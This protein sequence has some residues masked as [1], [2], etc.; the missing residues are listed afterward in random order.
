MTDSDFSVTT[1]WLPSAGDEL[2]RAHGSKDPERTGRVYRLACTPLLVLTIMNC[3][4]LDVTYVVEVQRWGLLRQ[5]L[6]Q[7]DDLAAIGLSHDPQSI[8]ARVNWPGVLAMLFSL[9]YVGVARST[10]RWAPTVTWSVTGMGCIAVFTATI[11]GVI[12]DLPGHATGVLL[13]VAISAAWLVSCAKLNNVDNI[14]I[15]VCHHHPGAWLLVYNLTLITPLAIGRWLFGHGVERTLP[16]DDPARTLLNNQTLLYLVCGISFGVGLWCLERLLP[17]WHER[18]LT[19]IVIVLIVALGPGLS[20]GGKY[21]YDSFSPIA[22]AA[23]QITPTHPTAPTLQPTT[24]VAP[25]LA[26]SLILSRS[27]LSNRAGINASRFA[28]TANPPLD[29]V[30]DKEFRPEVCL[31]FYHG[32]ISAVVESARSSFKIVANGPGKNRVDT[33]QQFVWIA[34][35][36]VL[37]RKQFARLEALVASCR[38]SSDRGARPWSTER[39]LILV[40]SATKLSHFSVLETTTKEQHKTFVVRTFWL[41]NEAVI[42]LEMATS[43]AA[44]AP[45]ST[46]LAVINAAEEQVMAVH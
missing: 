22:V 33:V 46:D 26:S 36:P 6:K 24:P 38:S 11:P 19:V 45:A 20:V 13:A 9:I 15:G 7:F 41:K 14:S 44:A 32:P 29:L 10:L 21:A 34:D 40:R 23:R 17:P 18:R 42:E 37:A 12:R 30:P 28:L 39:K 25:P 8:A 2:D 4:W 43:D 31:G 27:F 3:L 35:S 5:I 1:S 16:L